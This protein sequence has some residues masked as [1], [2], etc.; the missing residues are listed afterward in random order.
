MTAIQKNFTSEV[1]TLLHERTVK[2]LQ[3]QCGIVAENDILV[4]YVRFQN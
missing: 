2:K 1:R 4:I 3:S